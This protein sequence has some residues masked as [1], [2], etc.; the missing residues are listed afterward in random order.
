MIPTLKHYLMLTKPS[1]MLLVL[2][3]GTAGMVMQGDLLEQPVRFMLVLV[4]LF[5][6]GGSANAFNQFFERD[7][8]AQ[9][10][11][12]KKRRPLPQG[13]ISPRG[14][15]LFASG[16]GIAGCLL[17]FFLFNALSALLALGTILFYGLFYTL[18]LKPNTAQ[19]IV[20]GGA[21]GAMGPVIAWA[22]AAGNLASKD[23]TMA[24][25]PW[26]LF[27]VVFLWTP[28]HFWALAL[29]LKADYEK[30]KL[31][32]M[33]VVKGD[34]FTLKQMWWYT[35]A[36]VAISL[37]ILFYDSAG[38]IYGAVAI[39][40]G[41]KFIRKALQAMR[42]QTRQAEFGLFKFSIVYLLVLFGSLI[43]DGLRLKA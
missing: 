3:T 35:L 23:G 12:T 7:I 31:P 17:F 22:A 4:G 28:P 10:A 32:M 43:V 2:I 34:V 9:M 41:W 11:R 21:A 19:N 1:I 38:V 37:S 14:A 13:A 25:E 29:Y 15:F 27:L 33:P 6:T 18:Y 26:L 42:E 30:V 20:I 24:F 39:Y 16:I 36:T 5:C 8:D 40:L